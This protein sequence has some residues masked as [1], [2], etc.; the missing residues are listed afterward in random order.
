MTRRIVTQAQRDQQ[1]REQDSRKQRTKY[2]N[3]LKANTELPADY[4]PNWSLA[5]KTEY[6]K[7]RIPQRKPNQKKF[8]NL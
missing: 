4:D 2:K 8:F 3:V 1:R 7:K 5:E 6:L